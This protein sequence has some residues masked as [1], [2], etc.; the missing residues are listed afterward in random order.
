[1]KTPINIKRILQFIAL[2]V[3]FA[4]LRC[5]S[6]ILRFIG[7]LLWDIVSSTY[8]IIMGFAGLIL[9]CIAFFGFILWLFTL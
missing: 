3:C 8:R 5:I 6:V 9:S 4:T 7:N 2:A 1:M